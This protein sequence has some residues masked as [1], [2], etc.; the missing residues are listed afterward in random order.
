MSRGRRLVG[1]A[2]GA[3]E[4]YG[5]PTGLFLAIVGLGL[6]LSS[7]LNSEF[8]KVDGKIQGLRTEIHSDNQGLRSDN[9]GLRSE[10]LSA[11]SNFDNKLSNSDNRFGLHGERIRALEVAQPERK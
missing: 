9:Q 6:T 10:I 2:K 1:P 5:P 7:R 4:K 11:L 8:D 3:F